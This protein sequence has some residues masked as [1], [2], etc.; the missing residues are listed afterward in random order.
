MYKRQAQFVRDFLSGYDLK[1]VAS[2]FRSIR[3]RLETAD[4]TERFMLL[5]EACTVIGSMNRALKRD[6]S[7]VAWH[8]NSVGPK[9]L[10][11]FLARFIPDVLLLSET[12]LTRANRFRLPN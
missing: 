4:P 12:H 9:H 10:L 2:T 5:V 7:L 6:L 11:E 8:A 3:D 1:K